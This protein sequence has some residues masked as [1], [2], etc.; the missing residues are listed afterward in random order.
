MFEEFLADVDRMVLTLVEGKFGGD[1][2]FPEFNDEDWEEA[3]NA[4][5]VRRGGGE[6]S[7]RSWNYDGVPDSSR[8]QSTKPSP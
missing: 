5:P 1:I 7:V 4:R 8:I 3:P 6:S 2:F